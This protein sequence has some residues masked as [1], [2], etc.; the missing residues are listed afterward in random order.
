RP[1]QTLLLLD[2]CEHV[3]AETA[4]LVASLVAGC[5][6]LQILATS[7]APLQVRGEQLLPVEPLALPG[8]DAPP[9]TIAEAE[10]I[11]LFAARAR[12]VHPT[13]RLEPTNATTVALLC[14]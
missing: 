5:P 9:D 10:A 6:A 14:R 4:D 13:F 11:R 3:L 2:N 1:Q 8:V 7:R 12:A